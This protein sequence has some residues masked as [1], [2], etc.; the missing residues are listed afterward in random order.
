MRFR[1]TPFLLYFV[2]IG[3][4]SSLS[5]QSLQSVGNVY[6]AKGSLPVVSIS[7]YGVDAELL[8]N[9]VDSLMNLG[10]RERAFPGAQ[11]LVAFKGKTVFHKSYGFHT[12]DSLQPVRNSDLYDL[13]SV[14]K[15]SAAL[16][17]IMKLVEEGKLDLD[18]PFS[19]Y[20]KPWKHRKDKRDLTVREI[21]AHQAGL[22]P[23]IVYLNDVLK[24][25]GVKR[26]FVKQQLGNGYTNQAYD[27]L[28]IRDR[29]VR[30]IYRKANRSKV[31]EEKKYL[32]SGLTFLLYPKIVEDLS[33]VPYER[34][35]RST[36]YDPLGLDSLLFRPALRY[37]KSSIVPT[38]VDSIF[39]NELTHGWVHDENASLLGGISGNAGLFSTAEDL[40][41]LMQLYLNYGEIN[42]RRLIKEDVVREFARV[43]FPENK[44][45]RGVG[46]D[47]PLLNN[48]ELALEDAYPAPAASATSFGHTGFTGT[49]V[50]ADP[51]NQLVY[52][53]LSNR[54]YPSRQQQ[55]LYS[56]GLRSKVQQ[57]FYEALMP[58]KFGKSGTGK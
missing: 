54:V 31:S 2:L 6:V 14:T 23:Y 52:I 12:Y 7:D 53:F 45:R 37:P 10:I 28:F 48:A 33:G 8:N 57:L 56:L 34:F 35:I 4:I 55:A 17:A 39:R 3:I 15:I 24:G 25:G 41:V 29:F 11:V 20:W 30:K 42:G 5:A 1:I 22:I 36:I 26:R 18:K 16:P 51:E 44:N 21:L 9:R 40:G 50:W 43:Q 32:Y 49:M 58:E 47:K 46:F 13:A 19:T 38:E 27:D